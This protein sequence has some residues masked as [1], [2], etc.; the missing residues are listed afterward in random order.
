MLLASISIIGPALARISRWPVL[1]GEQGPFVDIALYALLAGVIVYDLLTRRRLHP[2]TLLGVGTFI[3]LGYTANLIAAT[4]FGR[5]F[6]R[7]LA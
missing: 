4:E 3:G 6:V 2:A 5:A 7:S 1:G